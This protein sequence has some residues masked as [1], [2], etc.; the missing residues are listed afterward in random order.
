MSEI[1]P[2]QIYLRL[3]AY[4]LLPALRKR[5]AAM[6]ENKRKPARDTVWNTFNLN[7][8]ELTGLRALIYEEGVKML[9]EHE[10]KIKQALEP[11]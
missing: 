5:I 1:Q 4:G 9:Q 11:A 7:E 3:S 10:F 2:P 6:R 8:G